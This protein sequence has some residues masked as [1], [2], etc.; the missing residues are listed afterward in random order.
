MNQSPLVEE[1]ARLSP[2]P[3]CARVSRIGPRGPGGG[4]AQW[5]N[6]YEDCARLSAPAPPPPLGCCDGCHAPDIII[7]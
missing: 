7:W 4:A 1:V 2:S 6:V 3:P 5:L